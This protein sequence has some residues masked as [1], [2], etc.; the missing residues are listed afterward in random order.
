MATIKPVA[1]P[2]FWRVT[3]GDEAIGGTTYVGELTGVAPDASEVHGEGETAFVMALAP[4]ADVLRELPDSGWL[5][6]GEVYQYGGAALMVRQAHYRTEHDPASVLNLFWTVNSTDAWIAGEWVAVGVLRTYGGKTWRCVQ[7]H[8][9]KADW[10]PPN[11]LALWAEV[12]EEP[13]TAEWT[14]GV[15][16]QVNDEVTYQGKLYR[17]IQAH[18][19]IVTWEPP[20]VLALW[21]PI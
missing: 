11:V 18:T 14:A 7:A 21:L 9:T 5:E 17:C 3:R 8:T 12:V 20:N 4:V 1:Q 16:Y 15:A 2:A 6:A 13:A 10:L 19:S